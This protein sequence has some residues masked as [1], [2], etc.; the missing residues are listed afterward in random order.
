M[1]SVHNVLG[2]Y[3][4]KIDSFIALTNFARDKYVQA[5]FPP[6]K[7]QVK[8]NF[9]R[10]DPGVGQGTGGYALFVGR[11]SPEKGISFMLEAWKKLGQHIPLRIVGDGPLASLVKAASTNNFE[12]QWLGKLDK[13]AVLAQM[14]EAT[15]LVFPSLW[16]E[17]FGN[18]L[19]EAYATGLPVIASN[20]GSAASIVKHQQTG[21]HFQPGSFPE[22]F[23]QVKR[24]IS[25]PELIAQLRYG[26][27]REFEQHYTAEQNY[28]ILLSIYHSTLLSAKVFSN[29][30]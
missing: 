30:N 3:R 23:A 14:K 17:T 4:D 8:P 21:L 29:K 16:Y 9:L 19:I 10:L 7:I 11:L 12:I 6:E 26:A 2:T 28:Q 18:V 1:L 20:L 25:A 22:L 5:G 13:A 15:F 27:R 24:L